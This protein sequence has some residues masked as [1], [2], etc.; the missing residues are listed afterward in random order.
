MRPGRLTSLA[1]RMSG[2]QLLFV[3]SPRP[4][5]GLPLLLDALRLLPE[6]SL[7]IAG[8]HGGS[9]RYGE[10]IKQLVASAQDAGCR[11]SL[12]AGF[13][14]DAELDLLLRSHSAVMLPYRTDF[15]AQSGVLSQAV[16]YHVPVVATDVGAVG[17][18]VQGLGLGCVVPPG[19]PAALA[20]GVRRLYRLTFAELARRLAEAG[21]ALSWNAAAS[22][23]SKV[24]DIVCP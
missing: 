21:K 4:N 17:E 14:P 9:R 2:R 13:V 10:Q 20:E 8:L 12:L 6:F 11:I 16:A 5:K 3:G 22:T 19:S 23:L 7:T 15:H 24:Y 1:E 18:T